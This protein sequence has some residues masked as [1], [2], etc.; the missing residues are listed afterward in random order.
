MLRFKP[1]AAGSGSK[2]A[3][4]CAMLPPLRVLILYKIM[5]MRL[6]LVHWNDSLLKVLRLYKVMTVARFSSFLFFSV[7]TWLI[8]NGKRRA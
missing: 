1:G 2:Y 7:D 5:V 4:H 3:N 8:E 6:Y